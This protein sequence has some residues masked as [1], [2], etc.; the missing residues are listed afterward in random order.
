M[1]ERTHGGHAML[2]IYETADGQYLA[3][4]GAQ[5]RRGAFRGIGP[6]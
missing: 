5:I 1:K 6:A 2:N 3:L 4:G